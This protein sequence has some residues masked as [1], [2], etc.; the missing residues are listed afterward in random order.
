MLAWSLVDLRTQ[1]KQRLQQARAQAHSLFPQGEPNS[2]G[3]PCLANQVGVMCA[4]SPA[5]TQ[6]E[7]RS[8]SCRM[9]EHYR[10]LSKT[11]LDLQQGTQH[12]S[13]EETARGVMGSF[14]A[15]LDPANIVF[16]VS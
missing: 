1:L 6:D 7:G 13:F 4:R 16:S 9:A 3:Q 15:V 5:V 8:R 11:V 14:Y 2:T 12:C 10:E